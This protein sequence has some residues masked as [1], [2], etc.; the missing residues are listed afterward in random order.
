MV[1]KGIVGEYV[2]LIHEYRC[3]SLETV[4]LFLSGNIKSTFLFVRNFNL[5]DISQSNPSNGI[6]ERL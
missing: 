4:L 2:P 3:V 5:G 6:I 1:I